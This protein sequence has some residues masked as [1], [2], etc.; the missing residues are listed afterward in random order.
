MA[1]IYKRDDIYYIDYRDRG[2]RIRKSLGKISKSEADAVLKEIEY[3]LSRGKHIYNHR[4]EV[5]P[6]LEQYAVY[7][8]RKNHPRH[9]RYQQ[10]YIK[11]FLDWGNIIFFSEINANIYDKYLATKQQL[12]KHTIWHHYNA[13]RSFLNWCVDRDIIG[14]NPIGKLQMS[15]KNKKP[16][17]F[18]TDAEVYELLEASAETSLYDIILCMLNFGTRPS[19]LARMRV[20]HINIDLRT[21][22][23]PLSKSGKFRTVPFPESFVDDIMRIIG[24]K[25]QGESLFG[26]VYLP[27]KKLW[28]A[29]RQ[30]MTFSDFDF[31]TLRHTYITKLILS[32]VPIP[33]VSKLA[34]HASINTTMIYV[35]MLGVHQKEAVNNLNWHKNGHSA[36]PQLLHTS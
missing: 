20:K 29:I 15:R 11:S 1:R 9:A 8:E 18:L 5:A 13:L 30:R 2:K 33:V 27:P 21:V 14:K 35:H 7:Q 32:G 26:Y 3:S 4:E 23:I 16:P 17:R 22:S 34:G 31:Y 25:G 28:D 19:E 12:S 10:R 24:K 36:E 6:A